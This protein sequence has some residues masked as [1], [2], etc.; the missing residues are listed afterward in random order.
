MSLHDPCYN[1]VGNLG[2]YAVDPGDEGDGAHL[3][4]IHIFRSISK[5]LFFK[6]CRYIFN[7]LCVRSFNHI[8][9]V[10]Q[11]NFLKKIFRV[12]HS[13]NNMMADLHIPQ[14]ENPQINTDVVSHIVRT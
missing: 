9:D 14:L 7:Q 10:C 6:T 1:F 8:S 11:G 2:V 13:D 5:N 4:Y 12:L 3:F